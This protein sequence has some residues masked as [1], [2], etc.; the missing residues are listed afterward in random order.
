MISENINFIRKSIDAASSVYGQNVELIAVT[1]TFP[2][3]DVSQALKC[4]IKHI[5][6]SKIQE[7]IPKFAALNGELNGIWKHFIGHLQ[8]NKAKK[9]VENFDLIHSLDSLSLAQDINRHAQNINKV[10]NCLIEVKVSKEDTK[11]GV[12]P[13]DVESFYNSCK[14]LSNVSIKGLMVITPLGSTPEESRN[15]FRS[16]HS[17][18]KKLQFDNANFGIL[19]MG[20]SDDYITAVEEGATMVRVGSAIFGKRDYGNK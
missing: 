6:E 3:T 14:N 10:Q 8:S 13:D 1:K 7:A 2:Y 19:S 5:G 16:I 11:T 18:F 17:L 20:M 9:A 4:S 15:Y 12:R